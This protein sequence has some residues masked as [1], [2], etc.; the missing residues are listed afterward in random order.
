MKM[1]PESER[2][3]QQNQNDTL[4][5]ISHFTS[6]KSWSFSFHSPPTC[7]FTREIAAPENAAEDIHQSVHVHQYF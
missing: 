6:D 2:I 7:L 5:E 3:T 4:A 1:M